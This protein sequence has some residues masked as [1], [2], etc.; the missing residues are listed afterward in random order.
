MNLPNFKTLF[1]VFVF[2]SI[3]IMTKNWN[4]TWA[5]TSASLSPP[6][7]PN[8]KFHLWDFTHLW[9]DWNFITQFNKWPHYFS[10][11]ISGSH[12][13]QLQSQFFMGTPFTNN[14]EGFRSSDRTITNL[15]QHSVIFFGISLKHAFLS[16]QRGWPFT[17]KIK[18]SIDLPNQLHN[19]SK[20]NL[21]SARCQP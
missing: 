7:S 13:S 17:R 12:L 20:T 9:S 11:P 1:F 16:Y 2:P 3:W 19:Q 14:S 10:P 5:N 21:S 8:S 6:H 4:L 18:F 15:T